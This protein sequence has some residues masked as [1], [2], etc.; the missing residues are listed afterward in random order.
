MRIFGT[1]IRLGI[2]MNAPMG[3]SW[4]VVIQNYLDHL[5]IERGLSA[6]TIQAYRRDL[7]S[8]STHLIEMGIVDVNDVAEPDVLAYERW[9]ST[10]DEERDALS[11]T[12][13]ARSVVSIRNFH[14]F[15]LSEGMVKQNPAENVSPPK[16]PARL[17]KALT[18]AQV[19]DLMDSVGSDTPE[20]LRDKAL[21]EILYG[22]GARVS[23]VVNLDVD[24]CTRVL[25][26]PELG[27]RILGKGNKYRMVPLGSYA[28]DALEGWL[29]RGRPHYLAGAKES[30]PAVFLNS[31]GKRLSRQSVWAILQRRAQ[32]A[33]L[34]VELSPHSLRHSFATHLLDGGADV[35]VVQELLGH[36]SVTTTQIYTYVSVDQLREVHRSAHPRAMI[37]KSESPER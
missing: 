8:Y 12:S 11:V 27:L 22:T 4:A 37:A 5:T 24:E 26:Q 3:T 17:P 35:R 31:L 30:T 36:S 28:R 19:Q 34:D 6:N 16:I 10:G 14:R 21:L 32:D 29:V 23:E 33:G 7:V 9:L 2:R 15:A 1:G 25:A 20:E 13:V 18:V